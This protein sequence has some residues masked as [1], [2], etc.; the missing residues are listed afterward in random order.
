MQ[1]YLRSIQIPDHIIT[2]VIDVGNRLPP[3]EWAHT[4]STI[5]EWI[6]RT[7]RILYR[8]LLPEQ[9]W[10]LAVMTKL[11]PR[12]DR[13]YYDYLV[14]HRKIHEA[15]YWSSFISFLRAYYK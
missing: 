14:A 3:L 8:Q 4:L 9:F 1:A 2:T 5:N 6:A 12:L 15:H 13:E 11:Y 10:A 7:I